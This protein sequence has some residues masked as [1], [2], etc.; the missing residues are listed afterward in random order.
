[1]VKRLHPR[2][3]VQVVLRGPQVE[4][5]RPMLTQLSHLVQSPIR[6]ISSLPSRPFVLQPL[7]QVRH[8]LPCASLSGTLHSRRERGSCATMH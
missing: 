4:D 3:F 7:R 5:R 1:M 8:P 2:H 6:A